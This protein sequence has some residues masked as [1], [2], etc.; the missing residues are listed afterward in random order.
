MSRTK[1]PSPHAIADAKQIARQGAI[2]LPL[3]LKD[4]IHR[5]IDPDKPYYPLLQYLEQFDYYDEDGDRPPAHSNIAKHLDMSYAKLIRLCYLLYADLTIFLSGWGEPWGLKDTTLKI[6]S[7][8]MNLHLYSFYNLS[9]YLSL[10][11]PFVPRGGERISL[12]L[13]N[14]LVGCNQFY[15]CDIWHHLDLKEQDITLYCSSNQEDVGESGLDLWQ[16]YRGSVTEL[17]KMKT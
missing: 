4:H 2:Y 12:D 16:K 15:V 1:K 3:M 13:G 17:I 14:Y 11:L 8:Q 6:S 10:R 9:A 5:F 7:Y